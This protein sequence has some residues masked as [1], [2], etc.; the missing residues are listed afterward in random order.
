MLFLIE[1]GQLRPAKAL[2]DALV[3]ML[4]GN[5]E[6]FLIDEQKVAFETIK[7]LV[8]NSLREVSSN[9]ASVGKYTVIVE[10]GPGT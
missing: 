8:H 3:S 2:Q 1:E 4:K 9:S 10:G 7:T 5:R 6:F